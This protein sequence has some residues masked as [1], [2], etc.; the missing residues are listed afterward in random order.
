MVAAEK[1]ADAI[2]DSLKEILG[3]DVFDAFMVEIAYG[4]LKKEIDIHTTII[5]RPELFESA[6]VGIFGKE[7]GQKILME[8]CREI[9]VK[10]R[11]KT[12]SHIQRL[13]IS[14]CAWQ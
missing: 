6:F 2:L 1:V 7:L 11:L 5:E 8:I 9:K 13:E 4:Y 14:P 3:T 12:D 10:F